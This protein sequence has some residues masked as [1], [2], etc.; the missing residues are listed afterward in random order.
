MSKSYTTAE[1]ARMLK[2]SS[3]TLYRYLYDGL[4]PEPKMVRFGRLKARSWSDKDIKRAKRLLQHRP[5][6]YGTLR[7]LIQ[8]PPAMQPAQLPAISVSSN[9]H[10]LMREDETPLTPQELAERLKVKESWIFEQTRRRASVRNSNP[11]PHHKMGK[12]LRFS[13]SEV[14][15]WLNKQ[16]AGQN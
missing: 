11:L 16:I 10:F 9:Y 3:R 12:Y 5:P 1:V 6:T 7:K 13:W 4:L 8:E 15:D 2:I 14:V